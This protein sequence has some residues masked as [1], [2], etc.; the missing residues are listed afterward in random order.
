M[1]VFV[2]TDLEGVAGVVTF[3][4]Q[5]TPGNPG[6][7]QARKLLT[8]EI[9]AAVEGL[10]EA[11]VEEVIV[12]D[13]HGPGG[14][15]YELLHPFAKL[16]HGRPLAPYPVRDEILRECDVCVMI[17]QHAMAGVPRANMNHTQSSRAIDRYTLNGKPIG[18]IAQFALYHG[19]LGLPLIFLSGDEEACREAEDLV[20][21]ITTTAVKR[22]LSRNCAL[23]LSLDESHRLIRAGILTAVER[24]RCHPVLPLVWPGPYTL[25][26]RFF[27]T[28]DADAAAAQ[29]GAERVDG[30]TVRFRGESIRDIIYR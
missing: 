24:H 20:P 2:G 7:E 23:S 4:V 15:N 10:I 27:H 11:D 17:G 25:E 6:Y 22:S 18:E 13:G 30:Q 1:K 9:N 8:W 12:C 21:S 29:R 16:L 3:Y 19:D 14:V 5:T 26:K 28:D